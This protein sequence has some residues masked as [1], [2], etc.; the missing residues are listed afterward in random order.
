MNF[1]ISGFA[2]KDITMRMFC[3]V[4]TQQLVESSLVNTKKQCSQY[5]VLVFLRPK[6]SCQK[7]YPRVLRYA[8]AIAMAFVL[9]VE[10]PVK[11]LETGPNTPMKKEKRLLQ[12]LAI[13]QMPLVK[14]LLEIF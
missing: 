13:G 5:F 11:K 6:E 9:D 3:Q 1:Q 8:I 12:K 10:E 14:H 7:Y 4:D 2:H